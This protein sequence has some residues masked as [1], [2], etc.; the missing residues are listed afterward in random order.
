M[1]VSGDGAATPGGRVHILDWASKK[2]THVCRATFSAEL[3]ALLDSANAAL[4]L[5]A[6][7]AELYWGS[8]TAAALAQAQEEG[9]LPIPLHVCCD[10]YSVVSAIQGTGP[11]KASEAHL[12]IHL[13]KM[14]EWLKRGIIRALWWTD[15]RD[16]IAD[17]LTKGKLSRE[18]ILFISEHGLWKLAHQPLRVPPAAVQ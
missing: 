1:L 4:K 14:R 3:F 9:K 7:I 13:L 15:T 12:A 5:S 17:G 2:Q 8:T 10:A 11:V 18:A 6:V 16:M